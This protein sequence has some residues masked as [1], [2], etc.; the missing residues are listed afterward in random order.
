MKLQIIACKR[1]QARAVA[2][3]VEV[4][5]S[6]WWQKNYTRFF[7]VVT[8]LV[9]VMRGFDIWQ[10]VTTPPQPMALDW[11]LLGHSSVTMW[12]GVGLG[13]GMNRLHLRCH[14]FNFVCVSTTQTFFASGGRCTFLLCFCV[15]L[16][17][18]CLFFC[19]A[20]VGG[21]IDACDK[22]RFGSRLGWCG[23]HYKN[24][25]ILCPVICR[26]VVLTVLLWNTESFSCFCVTTTNFAICQLCITELHLL[27]YCFYQVT[28]L[29]HA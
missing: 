25:P 14:R 8:S 3:L 13:L 2:V 24:V 20:A 26:V 4:A 19:F 12:P 1:K 16:L 17:L 15:F 22:D 9:V 11:H 6:L 21:W 23:C 27:F 7:Y 18:F 10:H 29:L 28:L 5:R